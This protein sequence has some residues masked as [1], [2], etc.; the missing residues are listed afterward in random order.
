MPTRTSR[1]DRDISAAADRTEFRSMEHTS[2]RS[3]VTITSGSSSES[4]AES[5]VYSGSFAPIAARTW[6]STS[7]EAV[8]DA[9]SKVVRWAVRAGRPAAPGGKSHSWLL[10]TSRSSPPMRAMIS[11]ADGSR[12]TTRMRPRTILVQTI[13]LPARPGGFR[14]PIWKRTTRQ[15]AGVGPVPTVRSGAASRF[16]TGTDPMRGR[17]P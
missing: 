17:R 9:A 3:C 5:S 15:S 7:A 11:V 8:A 2:H 14:R 6:E 13:P 1:P 12:L 10:P 16:D 4:R